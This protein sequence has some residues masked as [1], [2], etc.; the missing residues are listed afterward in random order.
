MSD[1]NPYAPPQ[2]PVADVQIAPEH[3]Q[4]RP[5]NLVIAVRLLWISFG[6]GL[7]SLP[8]KLFFAPIPMSA[9]LIVMAFSVAG[10]VALMNAWLIVKI[11]SGRNWARI[12]WI[13][14]YA[15]GV[16]AIVMSPQFLAG[17]SLIVRLINVIQFLMQLVVVALLLTPTAVQWFKQETADASTLTGSQG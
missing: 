7:I 17:N 9:P 3:A 8:L 11:A 16:C 5:L 6:I 15:I 13:V 4:R 14:L 12:V 2:A 1:I 10:I